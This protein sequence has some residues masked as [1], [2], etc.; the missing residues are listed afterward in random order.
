[1][2]FGDGFYFHAVADFEERFGNISVVGIN[3]F[4]DN[5]QRV[6]DELAGFDSG[7]DR[8]VGVVYE[9]YEPSWS[10]PMAASEISTACGSSV[11]GSSTVTYIPLRSS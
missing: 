7:V 4:C 8:T 6:V 10:E 1:M 11:T 9:I 5:A 2:L 3:A